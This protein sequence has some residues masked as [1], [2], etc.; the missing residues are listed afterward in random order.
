MRFGICSV[1]I[2]LFAFPGLGQTVQAKR[3][4]ASPASRSEGFDAHRAYEH[5]LQLVRFGP[6]PPGSEAVH[7]AQAYLTDQLKSFGCQVTEQ[8]FHGP[9]PLGNI[10]MKNIVAVASG[11]KSDIVLFTAHYDTVRIPNFVGAND[12]A[13]GSGVVLELA[14]NFCAR[15][16]GVNVWMVFFDGEEAQGSWKDGPS[17]RW[18]SANSTL[19]SREM[20]AR[21]A[22]SGQLKHVKAMILVDM[23]GGRDVK[24]RRDSHSTVWLND[25]IWAKA[26]QL[27]YQDLFVPE[28]QTVGGDDHFSFLKRGVAACDLVDLR[29]GYWHTTEDTIDK[30]DTAKLAVVGQ[31]LLESLPELEKKLH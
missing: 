26:G 27:G 30:I 13:A 4:A 16:N 29:Y 31:T 14:R 2:F 8:D 10:A 18:T 12:G 9:T 1:V 5:T 25:L 21:M 15:K 17:I 23:V 3:P 22:L 28:M 19:G 20:A 11:A 6:R 7:N 24:L